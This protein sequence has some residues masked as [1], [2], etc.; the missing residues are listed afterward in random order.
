MRQRREPLLARSAV[1][2]R[3]ISIRIAIGAGRARIIRQLLVESVVLSLAGGLF[4]WLLALS[5]LHWFDSS[6]LTFPKPPW[7]DLSM[8]TTVFVYLAAISIGTGCLFGL[9]PALQLAKVDVNNAIKSGGNGAVGGMRGRHLSSLLVALEMALCVVLL[10]GA[11]LM[12]RSAIKSIWHA[13]RSERR[14]ACSR[15]ASIYPRQSIRGRM[16]RSLFI[17]V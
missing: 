10:A 2:S 15:C 9:A 5:A 7:L 12:I 13:H 11:G 6:L 3:E 17:S 16:T 14:E 4:G 8:N 1:R